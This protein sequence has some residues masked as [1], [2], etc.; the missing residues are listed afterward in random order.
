MR[1]FADG[2]ARQLRFSDEFFELS[3]VYP[4]CKTIFKDSSGFLRVCG[5]AR[6]ERRFTIDGLE[7]EIH[8]LCDPARLETSLPKLVNRARVEGQGSDPASDEAV[9]EALKS[10]DQKNLIVRT[11]GKVLSLALPGDVPRLMP[12]NSAGG[13]FVRTPGLGAKEAVLEAMHS[14]LSDLDRESTPAGA[15]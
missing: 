1:S 15:G 10:L 7:A 4:C 5:G 9:S 2:Y 6:S 12:I 14:R 3:C 8:R 13:S 11:H